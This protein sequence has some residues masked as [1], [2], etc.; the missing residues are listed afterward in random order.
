MDATAQSEMINATAQK[1]HGF[2]LDFGIRHGRICKN[3]LCVEDAMKIQE[4]MGNQQPN[5]V[6]EKRC[7]KCGVVR[8]FSEY[9]F[10]NREHNKLRPYCKVCAKEIN[11]R[12]EKKNFQKRRADARERSR[13][14]YRGLKGKEKETY[15]EKVRNRFKKLHPILRHAVI[16]GYGGKCACCGETTTAFLNVDHVN[17]DGY[18]A[19]KNGHH[20]TSAQQFLRW[21]IK[22]NFPKTF[23]LLCWNCNLGKAFNGGICPHQGGST[24]IRKRSRTER[25]EKPSPSVEGDDMTSTHGESHGSLLN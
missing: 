14:W 20:P 7:N 15:L 22:N 25:S 13:E 16:E 23:Q 6:E 18:I 17:N 10:Y 8:P 1:I 5:L 11:R 3:I 19:R 4:V 9:Q 24:V 12:Y 21:L 2:P